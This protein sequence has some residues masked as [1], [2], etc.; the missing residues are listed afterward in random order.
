MARAFITSGLFSEAD[1]LVAGLIRE[2]K[3]RE[4]GR[5]K[6]IL[7]EERHIPRTVKVFFPSLIST[8]MGMLTL[9]TGPREVAGVS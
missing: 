3:L 2:D 1:R 7:S 8:G 9:E 4:G 6:N 5:G